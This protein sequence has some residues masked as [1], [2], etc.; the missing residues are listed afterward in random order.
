MTLHRNSLRYRL[1]LIEQ[2]T[3]P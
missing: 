1:R 2:F 3:G